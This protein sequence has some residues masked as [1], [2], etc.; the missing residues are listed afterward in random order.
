MNKVGLIDSPLS[1]PAAM[2]LHV[3][4]EFVVG[5]NDLTKGYGV[6]R[7]KQGSTKN[8]NVPLGGLQVTIYSVFQEKGI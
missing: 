1:S 5:H 4:D 6:E 7:G 2:I 8:I 3:H